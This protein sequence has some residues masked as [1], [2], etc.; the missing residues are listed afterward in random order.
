MNI[1]TILAVSVILGSLLAIV[2]VNI[3]FMLFKVNDQA[4]AITFVAFLSAIFALDV[5]ARLK[6]KFVNDKNDYQS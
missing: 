3:I 6:A 2:V 4:L 1:K 5:Q